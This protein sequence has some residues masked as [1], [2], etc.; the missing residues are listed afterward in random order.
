MNKSKLQFKYHSPRA[1]RLKNRALWIGVYPKD[2]V[3]YY[4]MSAT[5]RWE[6]DDSPEYLSACDGGSSNKEECTSFRKF[7]RRLRKQPE[8]IGLAE[9]EFNLT[10]V[11]RD[12]EFTIES[13]K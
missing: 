4:Y 6:T 11:G 12:Y 5:K 10:R 9:L 2:G 13:I 8:L 7:K 1:D 3:R